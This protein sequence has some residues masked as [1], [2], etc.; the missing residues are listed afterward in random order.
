MSAVIRGIPLIREASAPRA[1]ISGLKRSASHAADGRLIPSGTQGKIGAIPCCYRRAP[2]NITDTNRRI[3][4]QFNEAFNRGDLDSAAS[5]FSEDC[6]NHGRKVG[7][8]GVRTVL[9]EIKTNFPDARL[10]TLNSVAEGEGRCPMHLSRNPPGF[11]TLSGR[12][13]N[14]REYPAP[15][16]ALSRFSI[17]TCIGCSMARSLSILRIGTISG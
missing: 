9:E 11:V 6:Q 3:A 2:L 5:C 15:R 4:E 7:R 17:S 1:F 13:R 16:V 8:D 12:W 14:A 10:T